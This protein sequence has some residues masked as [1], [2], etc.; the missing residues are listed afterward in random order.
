MNL[1][2][3]EKLFTVKYG[4][5]FDLYQLDEDD[6]YIDFVSR[7]EKDNGVSSKVKSYKGYEPFQAGL[8][9]VALGGSVLA[10]FVQS[11]NFYT[12]QNVKVLS[13]KRDMSLLEKLYYCMVIKHNRFRYSAL[14]RE[15]NK[16]LKDILIPEEMPDEFK[17]IDIEKLQNLVL[18]I[19][20]EF[21][22]A[23]NM[24]VK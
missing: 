11:N 9:T 12:G 5:Q 22:R 17:A 10:S 23:S 3:L 16:T 15:A 19:N 18:D 1:V 21:K 2:P 8:I 14:G 7:G 24:I 20:S 4:N 13:P 6:G